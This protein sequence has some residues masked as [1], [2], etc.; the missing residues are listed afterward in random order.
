M[1]TITK[2]VKKGTTYTLLMKVKSLAANP[3]TGA[4][5]ITAKN[6]GTDTNLDSD[7]TGWTPAITTTATWVSQDIVPDYETNN[8]Y[9]KISGDSTKAN[10]A[11]DIIIDEVYIWEKLTVDNLIIHRHNWNGHGP[12][13][14]NGWK[15]SPLR[16]T[17]AADAN[18]KTEIASFT[19][20]T[21]A[22]IAQA[23]TAN[24]SPVYEIVLPAA[25]G[26]T[27]EVGEIRI[28]DTWTVPRYPGAF[29]PL[30]TDEG[31]LR[32]YK[33]NFTSLP[34]AYRRA[35]IERLFEK[36][37]DNESIDIIWDTDDPVL[38]EDADRAK[39]APYDPW[40][41]TLTRTYKERL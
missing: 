7:V 23:L 2:K 14:V 8:W 26:W 30:E 29:D 12:I 36:T 41:T 22:D 38:S 18:N 27:P 1:Q 19:P 16:S 17:S 6:T 11:T 37:R 10:G 4:L 28:S 34:P 9:I 25:A 24:A 15:L 3:T 20:E 32:V 33:F 31:G 5:T 35:Q 21:S 13:K 40:M 39:S